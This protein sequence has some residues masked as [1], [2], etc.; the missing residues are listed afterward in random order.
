M[1][2]RFDSLVKYLGK[3]LGV[4][5]ELKTAT[6]YA[7]VI[8]GM[9]FKHI[10][11]AYFGP[12]SYVEAAARANADAFALEVTID[13]SKGYYGVIITRKGHGSEYRPRS[14]GQDMGVHGSQ[15]DRADPRPMVYFLQELKIDPENTFPK[16][17]TPEVMRPPCSP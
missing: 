6:D 3:K 4:Q 2:E 11:L 5:V 1:T 7:A 9:Q 14:Q 15:F 8:T 12:K 16:S 13:G 10:D 17:S